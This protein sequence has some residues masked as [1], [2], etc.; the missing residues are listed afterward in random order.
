M[1]LTDKLGFGPTI[2]L[3]TR[4][5]VWDVIF[6][7]SARR[8]TLPGY[9]IQAPGTSASISAVRFLIYLQR[10]RLCHSSALRST[11]PIVYGV[12]PEFKNAQTNAYV[13]SLRNSELYMGMLHARY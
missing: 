9:C 7:I 8:G 1:H 11:C 13:A 5:I 4:S 2:A 12:R 3:G 10:I 6:I